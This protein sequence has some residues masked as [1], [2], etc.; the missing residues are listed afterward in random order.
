MISIKET[1]IVEGEY[2]KIKILSVVDANILVTGGFRIFKDKEMQSLIRKIAQK[3]GI[4][5]FTDSDRAG[6]LIR[7][8]LKN[9]TAGERVYH[10]FIPEIKGKEKRKAVPGKEGILGVEG[11]GETILLDA[12]R[13]SGATL[14]DEERKEKENITKLDLYH[15]GFYGK[16]NS[17][18][19]R[20][21]FLKRKGMPV[22]ISAN[23]LV[24]VMN[25][26]FDKKDLE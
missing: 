22:R 17:R 7:N 3:E 8:F 18:Q 6:F 14:S 1:I 19:K 25:L 20:E 16:E 21:E 4:V 5:I 23:M 11:M 2:D 26:L 9:T 10:A 12:L 15:A 13:R 24:E